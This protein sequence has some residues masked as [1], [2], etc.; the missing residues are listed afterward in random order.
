MQ[1]SGW[2]MDAQREKGGY[3]AMV[4]SILLYSCEAWP[5]SATD[6]R[7]FAVRRIQL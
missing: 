1:R 5:I 3:M 4:S 7:V 6:E 2:G